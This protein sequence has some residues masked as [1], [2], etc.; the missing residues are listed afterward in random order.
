MRTS[1]DTNTH[2]RTGIQ[3]SGQVSIRAP[4]G[5]S[6]T[7]A[8]S[9]VEVARG[10][11]ASATLTAYDGRGRGHRADGR[12][13]LE[14][15][16]LGAVRGEAVTLECVGEDAPAAYQAIAAVLGHA[17]ENEEVAP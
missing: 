2:D 6:A 8:R 3:S 9:L 4:Y 7:V 15:L 13:L 14:L 12:S 5:L 11:H 1:R 10:F 16:L 17:R